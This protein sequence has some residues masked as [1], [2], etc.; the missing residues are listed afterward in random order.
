MA[1]TR[2][3]KLAVRKIFRGK[4]CMRVSAGEPTITLAQ[5][6]SQSHATE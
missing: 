2:A 5:R 1:R 4:Q 3:A 6:S